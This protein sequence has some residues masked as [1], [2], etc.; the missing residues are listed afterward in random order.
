M[1]KI[2]IPKYSLGEELIN[3]ISHGIGAILSIVALIL[4]IIKANTVSG[5]ISGIIYALIMIV[6]YTISC[7]YHALSP[8]TKGKKVLRVIDHCNVMIMVAGTYMP[9]CLSLLNGFIGWFTF[10]FV[11]IITIVAVIFNCIDVDKYSFVSVLCNLI[12]GW[13]ALL[14]INPLLEV[15]TVTAVVL[16]IVGGIFYTVGSIL[17]GVGSKIPYMHSVFHFFVLA[18][19]VFHFMFIYF[20]CI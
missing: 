16:L 2:R 11:W 19:S 7:I 14:L 9:I 18:G 6:L 3:S 20:Y 1:N 10:F 15:T 12:L 4:C 5:L 13:G 8:R 17:Y